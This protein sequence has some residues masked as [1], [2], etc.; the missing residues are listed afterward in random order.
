MVLSD[1][2]RPLLDW[3]AA[4]ARDLPWRRDVTPYR[5]WVSE[6]MLQQTRVEAVKGYFER[7]VAAA[8]DVASL[9]ALPEERLLK[10]WEG[11]GYYSR[12][13]NLQKAARV[14]AERFGGALPADYDALLSLPGVGPYTAGA[15]ASIAFGQAVPAVDGNVLRVFT[16]LTADSGD[17]ADDA[18]KRRVTDAL[19]ALMP[20][21]ESGA[22]NQA[23]ME[24]GATVCLPN[25]APHCEDCPVRTE[26]KAHLAGEETNYPQKRPKPPRRVEERTVFLLEREGRLALRRRPGRGLLASLW[27]LPGAEGT[28]TRDEA[29]AAVRALGLEPLRLTPL[30]PYRHIFTH[31]E[32]RVSGWRVKLPPEGGGD[33]LTW[34]LPA[35]LA[36]RYPLPSA[37][38]P[39]LT[40]FLEG[41]GGENL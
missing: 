32:W 9:A 6:I 8:P 18:V 3:Y 7:F 11:L 26:C 28:L 27:E 24:L 15:V 29:V 37:F 36:A 10:L 39:C 34:A 21:G 12:A 20:A 14:C 30:A 33:G 1:I 40:A 22:F 19:A 41:P 13:R 4:N 23:L 2:V 31:V 25:A 16:R 5:V 38:R 17:I 35:E